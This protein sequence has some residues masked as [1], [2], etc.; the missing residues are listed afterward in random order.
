[1]TTTGQVTSR[2]GTRIGYLRDG[3]G[4]GIVLVQGAMGDAYNYRELA[5]A[6]SPAFTVYRVDRRGR[7]LSPKPYDAAHDIARDVEDIDALLADTGPGSCSASAPE[8]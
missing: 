5:E 3:S 8:P 6:L 7:G 4:P 1:M 2:D